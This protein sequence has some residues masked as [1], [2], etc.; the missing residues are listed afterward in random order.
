MRKLLVVLTAV[1]LTLLLAACGGPGE[2]SLEFE[3]NDMFQFTPATA[4]VP[5]GSQ[6][7]VTFN[8]VGVLEHNWVLIPNDVA[9]EQARD[10]DA[11]SGAT[12]GPVAFGGSA[13]FT[14]TAPAAG[15][16]K[17]VCTVPGHAVGGMV[18]TLTVTE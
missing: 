14:F 9:P 8:N 16:Y 3:G 17:F 11:I 7:T 1:T 10:S 4:V 15:S 12:S 13:T 5:A 18:G 6:V 2:V